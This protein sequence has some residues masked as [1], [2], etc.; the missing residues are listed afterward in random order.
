MAT[1]LVGLSRFA[2]FLRAL[3]VA[4]SLC[5]GCF[6]LKAQPS[7]PLIA[8]TNEWRYNQ[9]GTN[10]GVTWRGTNYTDAFWPLGRGAFG[11]DTNSLSL[12]YSQIVTPLTLSNASHVKI[13]TYYFRTHF[14]LTN[15]PFDITV[16]ITNL[17]DDGAVFYVNSNEVARF[18]MPAAPATIAY[19][20]SASSSVDASYKSFDVP[21]TALIRGENTL[22]VEVHN[23]SSSSLDIGFGLAATV[24]YPSP[25]LIVITNQPVSQTVPDDGAVT[26]TVGAS[27]APRAF[28]WFKDGEPIANATGPTL[29]LS[30]VDQADAGAYW[31]TISNQVSF[32]E[33][34]HATLN[35]LADT[36]PPVLIRAER[37]NDT[38]IQF[39]FSEP[40]LAETA[41]NLANYAVTNLAGGL[42]PVY[43]V[44]LIGSTNL[45]LRTEVLS[46]GSNY[47]LMAN[48]VQDRSRY[49]NSAYS[50]IP[51]AVWVP[52]LNEYNVWEF[53]NPYV[54]QSPPAPGDDNPDLGTSWRM[55]DYLVNQATNDFWGDNEFAPGAFWKGNGAIPAQRGIELSASSTPTVYFLGPFYFAG[56]PLG[57]SI[58]LE[59]MVQDGAAFYLNG[60]EIQRKNL[61]AGP[62]LWNTTAEAAIAPAWTNGVSPTTN[63][64]S[65]G[66]NVLAAE[67]HSATIPSGNVAFAAR[68]SARVT[69]LASGPVLITQQPQSQTVVES[70]SATFSFVAAGA[71]WFQWYQNG[72]AIPGAT[73]PILNIPNV[74]Y[75]LNNNQYSVLAYNA[76]YSAMSSNAML[77]VLMDTNPPSLL[78]AYVVSSNQIIASFSKPLDAAS[79]TSLGNYAFTNAT[80]PNLSIYDARLTNGT[81]VILTVGAAAPGG[82]VLVVKNLR[83]TSTL[84][85]A[86][87]PS[88]ATMG[89]DMTIPF[90]AVWKYNNLGQDLGTAWRAVSYPDNTWSN[91]MGLI[92]NENSPL[93]GPKNTLLPLTSP[94]GS[95]VITYYFRQHLGLALVPTNTIVSLAHIIDDAAIFY[96]N[97]T[98]IQRFNFHPGTVVNYSSYSDVSVE[99]AALVFP[100]NYNLSAV[101]LVP[102]DNV[103]AAEVHQI[104]TPNVDFCF[105]AQFTFKAP[106]TVT[107]LPPVIPPRMTLTQSG[108]VNR[109]TW[110]NASFTLQQTA[111]LEG[112]NT[113]WQTLSGATSPFLITNRTGNV[114]YRLSN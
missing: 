64:L 35:V 104:G 22:A 33:S 30:N 73:N 43:G 84:G 18:N 50:A 57:T 98:E 42:V 105:G 32:V 63:G 113:V 59:Y 4:F 62:I 13:I 102:G 95:D 26:F 71:A 49:T 11:Y 24:I 80:A 38:E 27:G 34:V 65:S 2:A 56:S 76:S 93:P 16:T 66:Y 74:A 54:S 39:T 40:V 45:V 88:I 3:I 85:N 10:L 68:L 108:G 82:Y 96:A 92:Y 89:L 70:Q 75:A 112:T 46:L 21:P 7:Y 87:R 51:V 47:V 79:T 23:V 81:N 36:S 8:M 55:P 61:P 60:Q 31:V 25:T 14:T 67:L 17:I 107:V 91:G 83:D 78:G 12:L 20:T 106:S 1:K 69:S 86:L 109:I 111:A 94:S 28:Q 15:N 29:S 19:L 9:G 37:T 114:F 52:L 5:S 72:A 44:T 77:T 53:Y 41:T 103:L 6:A 48:H 100:V 110:T 97:N 90:D 58:A 101:P 99:N